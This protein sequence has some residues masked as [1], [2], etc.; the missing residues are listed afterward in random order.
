MVLLDAKRA[1]APMR[2]MWRAAQALLLAIAFFHAPQNVHGQEAAQD[3]LRVLPVPAVVKKGEG[4]LRDVLR[5]ES[6]AMLE[7]RRKAYEAI[8]GKEKIAEYQKRLRE[9]FI[10]SLGGFPERTPLNARVTGELRGEGFRVEKVLF[11]SQPGFVVSANLYLPL[12]GKAP[13]PVVLMPC[14]HS[15]SGK[16]AYQ[17]PAM[18]LAR[19][20][21]AVFCFDP[22]GQGER[23][24][25]VRVEDVGGRSLFDPTV[26]HTT[27]AVAPILLGRNLVTD[28]IW[29]GMRAVD[30][31]ETR[32]DLDPKRIAVSGNSGGG[33]MTSYLIALEPR[34]VAAAPGCFITTSAR[35]N[36]HPGPGDPEQDIFAQ[37]R[38]GMD[39]PDYLVMAAPRPVLILSATRDYVPIAGAWEA[40]RDAKRIYTRLGYPERI[41]LVETD[42]THGFSLQLREG[43]VRWMRRWL[44]GIDE[45]V[46][47][48][49]TRH[50]TNEELQ[51]TP[52]GSVLSLPGARSIYDLNRERAAR[53]AHER[54]SVW[55]GLTDAARRERI[56]E[57]AN[58]RNVDTLP[59]L[60]AESRGSLKRPGM[61]IERLIFSRD[62]DVPLPALRF[63]PAQPAARACLYVHGAGKQADAGEDGPIAKLVA[64]GTEVLAVDLRGFGETSMKAWR[65]GPAAVAGDNGA[66]YLVAYMM[67]RSLLG[68]RAEDIL[69]VVKAWKAMPGGPAA[70]IEMIALEDA[71]VPA[72]NAAAAYPASFSSVRLVRSIESWESVIDATVPHRQLESAIHGVLR[73]YD[74]TD[75]V[76]LAGRVK[77]VDPVDGAGRP[78]GAGHSAR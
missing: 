33:M 43:A 73:T 71:A 74:L 67:G 21:L 62:G 60:R 72:L 41:D 37:Y 78:L 23:R 5:Q 65:R 12:E 25:T 22:I 35:K 48:K 57:V 56:R 55:A 9:H 8:N 30:Y 29:D 69:G 20:G 10:E 36:E 44:L 7:K 54:K 59:P 53:L 6:L 70:S 47:E 50:F 14:G 24:Q 68:M 32:A 51:C 31:L 27:I 66:E 64:D 49:E 45:P 11:E 4:P 19:N 15:G 16:A 1:F 18:I 28:M 34:L 76:P 61:T 46:F 39:I 17:A 26:E 58:I 3:P 38:Y 13:H 77:Y 75:L 40:F 2:M 52:K 63:T 42:A